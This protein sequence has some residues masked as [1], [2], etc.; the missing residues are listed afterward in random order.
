MGLKVDNVNII[1]A[2]TEALKLP[3]G[4]VIQ[5]PGTAVNGM[6]RY[7]TENNKVEVYSNG[8][9]RVLAITYYTPPTE[10]PIGPGSS[11][12]YSWGLNTHGEALAPPSASLLTVPVLSAQTFNFK[13]IVCAM[14]NDI[15]FVIRNDDTLWAVGRN[16]YGQLGI[17]DNVDRITLTQVG[18]ETWIDISCY[19]DHVAGIKS[20]GSLWT[21][22][23][24]NV[25]QLGQ[26]DLVDYNVPNQVGSLNVWSAVACGQSHTI[27][28]R[29]DGTLWASGLNSSGQ[30][31]IG[32]TTN[33]QIMTK[34]TTTVTTAWRKVFCSQNT[35]YS[36]NDDG[37]LYSWGDNSSGEMGV[38]ST[39]LTF[40]IPTRITALPNISSGNISVG[41]KHVLAVT[42][43][44]QL[45]RWGNNASG[46]LS[47]GSTADLRTPTRYGTGANWWL[48]AAGNDYSLA[49]TSDGTMYGCGLNNNAQLG[50][51][52]TV[53]RNIFEQV[54]SI[55][56]GEVFPGNNQVVA[57]KTIASTNYGGKLFLSSVEW[58]VPSGVTSICVA[59]IGGGASAGYSYNDIGGGGGA[60]AYAN[61][62]PVTAGQKIMINVGASGAA[63]VV[64]NTT[65]TGKD[66][67]DSFISINGNEILRA[68]G[69]KG[70]GDGGVPGTFNTTYIKGTYGGFPGGAGGDESKLS[71]GGNG[72]GLGY[73]SS[74]AG[75]GP[76]DITYGTGG[77][78]YNS[79]SYG[80]I[81][82]SATY[83]GGG[84]GGSLGLG[85]Q[86]T[87][88]GSADY[89]G[90]TN[91]SSGAGGSYGGGGGGVANYNSSGTYRTRAGG[92][93]AVRII[94]GAGRSFPTFQTEKLGGEA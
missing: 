53:N 90:A 33:T 10:N 62:I 52:D 27:A 79:S 20:N 59:A 63:V 51:D 34:S 46:Q 14:E 82:T 78:G 74:G 35:S 26:G 37:Y 41:K 31:G 60:A 83:G 84:G 58:E 94:W 50:L 13:K 2:A 45:F 5:R 43:A 70:N 16:N 21:W 15:T 61:N 68:G 44:Q 29:N 6:I 86:G 76:A 47:T 81:T 4:T 87:D 28:T 88:G 92:Q 8:A 48:C 40:T 80:G 36:V 77:N 71:Y 17:G 72:N 75:G 18:N 25:G 66:G 30:L 39:T 1:S 56:W 12:F 55:F 3:S 7:N 73:I 54:N 69:G 38:N 67:G 19:G 42:S 32:N 23:R 91:P 64:Y 89:A 11:V 93:G 57:S 49:V 85:A 22:G 9:W 24:N 65:D